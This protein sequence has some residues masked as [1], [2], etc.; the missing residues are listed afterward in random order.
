MLV[1]GQ[2]IK[3]VKIEFNVLFIF[4]AK[5]FHLLLM[6]LTAAVESRGFFEP[7]LKI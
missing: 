2:F 5:R 6:I 1:E 7:V 4:M 3:N